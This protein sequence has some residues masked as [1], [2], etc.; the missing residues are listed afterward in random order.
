[1]KGN[2][3]IKAYITNAQYHSLCDMIQKEYCNSIS[4]YIRKKIFRSG[5]MSLFEKHLITKMK[6]IESKVDIL[7]N[8]LI[9]NNRV[10]V[11]SEHQTDP[12]RIQ[13]RKCE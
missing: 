3:L 9:V 10:L 1:M 5:E 8:T 2:K 4:E 13:S 6:T 7:L 11:S 12:T